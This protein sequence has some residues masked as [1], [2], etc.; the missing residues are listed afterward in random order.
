MNELTL[1]AITTRNAIQR[2]EDAMLAQPER[3]TNFDKYLTHY[4]GE[5]TYVREMRLPKDTVIVGR[6]HRYQ[7]VCVLTKGIIL[8]KA[9]GAT[10]S[11]V[12]EAPYVFTAAPG[13]K[14]LYILENAIFLNILPNPNNLRDIDEL[15]RELTLPDYPALEVVS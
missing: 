7:E 6:I 1:D 8:V 4:F 11:K 2:L 9:D 10:E 5:G 14:V 15:E 12:Y 13:K 3:T